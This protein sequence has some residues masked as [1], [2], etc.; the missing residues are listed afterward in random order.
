MSSVLVTLFAGQLGVN[1]DHTVLVAATEELVR[2]HEFAHLPSVVGV[3]RHDQHERMHERHLVLLG[4]GLKS[5]LHMLVV[6][7]AIL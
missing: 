4:I 2:L 5:D 7:D 1:L 3:L 6:V